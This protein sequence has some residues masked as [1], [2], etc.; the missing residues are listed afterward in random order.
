[1]KWV[2][3]STVLEPG[4]VRH[5]TPNGVVSLTVLK[6]ERSRDGHKFYGPAEE[7]IANILTQ[8]AKVTTDVRQPLAVAF[9]VA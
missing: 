7:P 9:D 8:S 6:S 1:M 2:M 4:A 5:V 3:I